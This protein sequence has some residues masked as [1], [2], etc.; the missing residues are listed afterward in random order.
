MNLTNLKNITLT[1]VNLTLNEQ[2]LIDVSCEIKQ[3][4]ITTLVGE[5]GSGKSS[6]LKII[7]GHLP[8]DSGEIIVSGKKLIQKNINKIREQLAWIPNSDIKFPDIELN[9]F[10]NN[11]NIKLNLFEYNLEKFKLSKEILNKT[12][13]QIS[14]GEKQRLLV[15]IAVNFQRDIWLADEITS[16][17]DNENKII[18]LDYLKKSNKTIFCAT[19]D[20]DL[21]DIAD[22]VFQIKNKRLI[23]DI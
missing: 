15:A 6:L 13:S 1:Q 20:K 14:S 22:E 2:L 16:S 17:L 21:I 9:T 12:F 8:F 19:H 3:G 18:V 11:L 7:L 23:N 5:S 4:K 10:V